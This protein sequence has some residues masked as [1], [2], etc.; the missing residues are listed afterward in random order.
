MTILLQIE[1]VL[2]TVDLPLPLLALLAG[3]ISILSPCILPLLPAI[4]AYSTGRGKFRPLAI[5]AGLM[6]TFTLMGM[7]MAAFSDIL[8][9]FQQYIRIVAEIVI[10]SLGITMLMDINLELFNRIPGKVNINPDREGVTGGFILGM[11]LGVVWIP[12]TGPILAAILMG[13]LLKGGILYG[14]FLLFVYSLGL[15]IPMLLIAYGINVSGKKL[16]TL[17]RYDMIL[18]RGAGAVLIVLGLWM[19]YSYHIRSFFIG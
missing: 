4:L 15:G 2:S 12:C 13:V 10:I 11:S 1:N 17:S 8:I 3:I 19:V 18:K 7:T 6:L 5:V 16:S 9:P 14:G